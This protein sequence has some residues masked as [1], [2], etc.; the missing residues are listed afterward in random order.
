[1]EVLME[2]VDGGNAFARSV[3]NSVFVH[4]HQP[5]NPICDDSH[6]WILI[7]SFGLRKS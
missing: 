7:L 3:G 6:F 4:L 2:I 1:M 5:S